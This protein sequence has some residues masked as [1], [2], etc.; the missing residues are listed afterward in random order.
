MDIASLTR[1]ILGLLA[2]G[3]IYYA[4]NS[5]VPEGF[6]R[7]VGYLVAGIVAILTLAAFLL[8][9]LSSSGIIR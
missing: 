4:T 5:L 8:S 3:L 7:T 6:P 9:F 2:A 1:L